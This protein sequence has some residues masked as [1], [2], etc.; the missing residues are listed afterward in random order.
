MSNLAEK[1]TED[2]TKSL[3]VITTVPGFI[4]SAEI[5]SKLRA[6]YDGQTY[7]VSTTAGMAKAVEARRELREVRVA[8]DKEKPKVKKDLLILSVLVNDSSK[9]E[10]H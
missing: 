3:A 9:L 8:L 6:K 4:T 7:D 5:I 2:A 10:I 1:I